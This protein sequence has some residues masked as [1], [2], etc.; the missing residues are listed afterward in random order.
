MVQA[1]KLFLVLI[2]TLFLRLNKLWSVQYAL[3]TDYLKKGK[4][5]YEGSKILS[6]YIYQ[7]FHNHSSFLFTLCCFIN[8]LHA[9]ESLLFILR[10]CSVQLNVRYKINIYYKCALLSALSFLILTKAKSALWQT[11]GYQNKSNYR[12]LLQRCFC[13]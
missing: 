9:H 8:L 10:T 13:S 2:G 7:R 5:N 1:I 6:M 3:I 12:V 11:N 4:Q